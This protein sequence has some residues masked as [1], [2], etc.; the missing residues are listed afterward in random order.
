MK[1]T[2]GKF[3]VIARIGAKY[4][5]R[6]EYLEYTVKIFGTVKN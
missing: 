1:R 2:V 4:D 3:A 5:P 6:G